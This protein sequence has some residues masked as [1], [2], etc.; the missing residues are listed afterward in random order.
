MINRIE[1]SRFS[2]VFPDLLAFIMGLGVAWFLK[3]ETTD[4]VWSLWLWSLA[5]GYRRLA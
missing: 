3:W 1:T 4:L 2:R 5:L